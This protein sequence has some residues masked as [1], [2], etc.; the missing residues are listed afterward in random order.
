MKLL[1][2]VRRRAEPNIYN[3]SEANWKALERLAKTDEWKL[4]KSL[5][6]RHMELMGERLLN[7]E[8]DRV[9]E[10]RGEIKGF[11]EAVTFVDDLLQMKGS[12]DA[13]HAAARRTELERVTR[14]ERAGA[15]GPFSA[16]FTK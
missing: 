4:Y 15:F 2:L 6:H 12:T 16:V 7:A 3:L 13:R 1:P 10:A 8:P 14:L 5:V 11:R 9:M